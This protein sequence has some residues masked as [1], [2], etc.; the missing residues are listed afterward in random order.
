MEC[1]DTLKKFKVKTT[2]VAA[3]SVVFPLVFVNQGRVVVVEADV[4]QELNIP[5]VLLTRIAA[6]LAGVTTV[7]FSQVALDKVVA[8]IPKPGVKRVLLGGQPGSGLVATLCR[9][10][11]SFRRRAGGLLAQ[12]PEAASRLRPCV[13]PP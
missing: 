3:Q 1:W 12:A 6:E 13:D 7:P 9:L 5:C 8:D 11:R 10:M 2:V 4:G